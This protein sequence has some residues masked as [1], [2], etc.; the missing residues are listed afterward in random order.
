[1][2]GIGVVGDDLYI[3]THHGMFRAPAG[4]R[5]AAPVGEE[6]R[7]VMGFS[8]A[9][10]GRFLG[11]GHPAPGSSEPP[12]LGLI[13][14]SDRGR[15]WQPVALSG[16]ADLH[17]LEAAGDRV[18]GV[19]AATGRLLVSGDGGRT[20]AEAPPP[21]AVL[22]LAISPRDPDHVVASTGSGLAESRDAG[23]TWRLT[24]QMRAGLLEWPAPDRLLLVS[25]P[26]LV[27][28]SGDRG[29]TWSP[30]A[31][32]DAE[33]AAFLAQ[34]GQAHLALADGRVLRSADGGRTWALRA[35]VPAA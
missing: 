23:R 14:S 31:Q 21:A 27:E 3:A 12:A 11:S 5:R 26:G 19:D 8:V 18:Y 10:D 35:Q 22:S 33:P 32:L 2:H 4:S 7:D 15:T 1:V 29:R 24:D 30:V 28:A 13:A 17:V 20:F 34:A 6:G 9:A 16:E 25:G